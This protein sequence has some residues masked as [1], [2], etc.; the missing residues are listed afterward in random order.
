MI[1]KKKKNGEQL[2]IARGSCV[3]DLALAFDSNWPYFS[4]DCN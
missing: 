4:F 2:Q 3:V 1:E